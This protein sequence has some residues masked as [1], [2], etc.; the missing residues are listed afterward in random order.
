MPGGGVTRVQ[1]ITRSVSGSPEATPW[2]KGFTPALSPS[3]TAD[4]EQAASGAT[5]A[6]APARFRKSRR[7]QPPTLPLTLPMLPRPR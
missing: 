6:P 1:S 2:L 3:S 7:D 5:A 4:D